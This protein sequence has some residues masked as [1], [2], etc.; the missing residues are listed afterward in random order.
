MPHPPPP[1]NSLVKLGLTKWIS[2]TEN[3]KTEISIGFKYSQ[4]GIFHMLHLKSENIG[5][6]TYY[7]ENNFEPC[8]T[9]QL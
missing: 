4:N 7:R 3:W 1:E 8:S 9:K 2:E 5:L 6:S